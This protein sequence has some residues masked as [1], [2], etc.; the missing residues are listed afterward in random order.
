MK[1]SRR[2]RLGGADSARREFGDWELPDLTARDI[3]FTTRG[4]AVYAFV[5]GWPEGEMGI[6]P[7]GMNSPQQPGKITKVEILG[8]NGAVRWSQDEKVLR[9]APPKS[10]LSDIG[11]TLKVEIVS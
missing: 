2:E 8:C 11:L 9:V 1:L 4:K 10:K 7:L 5:M 6:E 3:R